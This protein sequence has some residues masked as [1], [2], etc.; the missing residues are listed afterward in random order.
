M[1]I[2]SA[3]KSRFT[4]HASRRFQETRFQARIR[5]ARS[6]HRSP[7]ISPQAKTDIKL[8]QHL[9]QW[10]LILVGLIVVLFGL[11]YFVIFSDYFIVRQ[12]QVS[13]AREITAEMINVWLNEAGQQKYWNIIPKNNWW[14]LNTKNLRMILDAKSNRILNLSSHRIWPNQ[15]KIT[16]EERIPVAIWETGNNYFYLSQDS[17]VLEQLPAG[18]ATSTQNFLRIVDLSNKSVAIGDQLSAVKLIDFIQALRE[19]WTQ[20]TGSEIAVIR[21]PARAS[22]DVIVQSSVGWTAYLDLNSDPEVQAR[23]LGLIFLHEIPADRVKNL[24]YID[25]RLL[26]TAYYCYTH[27]PCSALTMPSQ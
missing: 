7:K 9:T 19:V 8:R 26:T 2:F 13:G 18:Y 12:A 4:T 27:E 5:Q 14:L 10:K 17:V 6:F 22:T 11:I 20:Q 3:K 1:R 21:L 25:I 23:L 15:I 24:S 16:L